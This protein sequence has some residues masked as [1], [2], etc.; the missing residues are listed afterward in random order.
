ML[1]LHLPALRVPLPL[2]FFSLDVRDVLRRALPGRVEDQ[3]LVVL[4]LG[5]DAGPGLEE[6]GC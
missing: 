3:A 6:G 5:E 1:L 4:R 2:R